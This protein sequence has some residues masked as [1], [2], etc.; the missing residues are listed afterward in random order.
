MHLV[1]Q[2]PPQSGDTTGD[3]VGGGSV[4][5]CFLN[6][7]KAMCTG[8]EQEQCVCVCSLCSVRSL[9]HG[10]LRAIKS[11]CASVNFLLRW[12]FLSLPSD[13]QCDSF[14][15]YLWIGSELLWNKPNIFPHQ[16]IFHAVLVCWSS[17]ALLSY[18]PR[19]TGQVESFTFEYSVF[20]P[21]D[22]YMSDD[23]LFYRKKILCFYH[24]RRESLKITSQTTHSDF[25]KKGQK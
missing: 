6:T 16:S 24:R 25:L 22:R 1:R 11:K 21:S 19:D 20:C 5:V 15:G 9:S 10:W 13:G 4:Y 2:S 18:G 17:E 12:E 14:S 23:A 3:S 8:D 7:F